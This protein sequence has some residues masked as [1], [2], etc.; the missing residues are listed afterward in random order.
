MCLVVIAWNCHPRYPL[1]IAANRDEEHARPTLAADWW[2][3]VPGVYGGRDQVAGGSWLAVSRTGRYALVVNQP[4]RPPAP[5]HTAS[6]GQLV[7]AWVAGEGDLAQG[8]LQRVRQ[9]EAS[10]AGFTLVV[11]TA[12]LRGPEA[13]VIP[14]GPAGAQ[15]RL[16]EGINALSNSPREDPMPKAVW[17]ERQVQ[18]L[19]ADDDADPEQLFALLG[20]RQPVVADDDARRIGRLR[21]TPFLEGQVYGTRA[22][23]LVTFDTG[24]HCR[25]VERRFGPGGHPAGENRVEFA[26]ESL[27]AV[28]SP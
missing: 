3:D 17:L 25:V 13:V 11:G 12:G 21:V 19:L 1:L 24:G 4:A 6:R 14:S 28:R 18:Q 20:R 7:R 10:Y 9:R 15:W 2:D 23:T 5:A 22:S 26:V 8:Y 27:A 16:A